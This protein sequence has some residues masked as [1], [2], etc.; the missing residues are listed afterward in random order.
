MRHETCLQ[1]LQTGGKINRGVGKWRL[2]CGVCATY[3]MEGICPWPK[4][5]TLGAQAACCMKFI[6]RAT[7]DVGERRK[8]TTPS[9]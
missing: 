6:I 2:K 4:R 3:F 1:G 5:A 7:Y 8:G 9:T